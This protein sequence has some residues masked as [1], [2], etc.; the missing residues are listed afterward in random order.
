M[1]LETQSSSSSASLTALDCYLN[2]D[3][4]LV[5]NTN[6]SY[7]KF[8]NTAI[9]AVDLYNCS[10]LQ[11]IDLT[12][13]QQE[14]IHIAIQNCPQLT[15]IKLPLTSNAYIHLDA[16]KFLP[17]LIIE[18]GVTHIDA[19]W[20]GGRFLQQHES[21]KWHQVSIG[22]W[23]DNLFKNTNLPRLG[24]EFA[25]L[26]VINQLFNFSN[27]LTIHPANLDCQLDVTLVGIPKLQQLN[28]KATSNGFH[29]L[30]V[31]QADDLL[32]VNLL[33]EHSFNFCHIDECKN[34][35]A[36][37]SNSPFHSLKISNSGFKNEKS[38]ISNNAPISLKINN[39]TIN[40]KPKNLVL[41]DCYFTDFQLSNATKLQFIRCQYLTKV[42]IPA[43]CQITCDGYVP[44]ALVGL[45][46]VKINESYI[47]Q[48]LPDVLKGDLKAWELMK[49]ILSTAY[50]KE[51]ASMAL[52]TLLE[53][54]NAGM[55][56]SEVWYLRNTIYIKNQ[57]RGKKAIKVSDSKAKQVHDT[58]RWKMDADL[59]EDGWRADWLIACLCLDKQVDGVADY[60]KIM[61]Y[62]LTA[63]TCVAPF[64]LEWILKK[65]NNLD[66]IA[67]KFIAEGFGFSVS[68]HST[69]NN[70]YWIQF[71]KE[72][73]YFDANHLDNKDQDSELLNL[74]KTIRSHSYQVLKKN[75]EPLELLE[76]LANNFSK[77]TVHS[78]LSLLDL[79][80]KP[81]TTLPERR[82]TRH[83]DS[84]TRAEFIAIAKGLLLTGRLSV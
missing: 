26:L 72:L 5:L 29:S 19:C 33:A 47:K 18:G 15:I 4:S 21:S 6:L 53:A 77:N 2:A 59:A 16:G 69:F 70:S 38:A 44:S 54:L 17:Q 55:D 63:Y 61:S 28:V 58:W 14:E 3:D 74:L 60:F 76:F 23:N 8:S 9:R 84:M 1:L 66:P 62:E 75:L 34:F 25:K 41:S 57:Y 32:E 52:R 10:Q 79:I 49:K 71:A 30:T 45:T 82:Y 81:P 11:E 13:S 35:Q 68:A 56:A 46:E 48:T 64:L 37:S 83:D 78:R 31:L 50:E 40:A 51:W 39:L 27:E 73:M 80:S 43:S 22:P 7:F 12:C 42:N 67:V 36:L 24:G 65:L 20:K